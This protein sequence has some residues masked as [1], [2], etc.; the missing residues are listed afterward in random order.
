MRSG[1]LPEEHRQKFTAMENGSAGAVNPILAGR[2]LLGKG[3]AEGVDTPEEHE[4]NVTLRGKVHVLY[5]P[6]GV[7]KT[8]CLQ[9]L[10]KRAVGRGE[11]V[12]LLDKENGPRIVAERLNSMGVDAARVDEQLAYVPYPNLPLSL[13]VRT[14]YEELLDEWKPDLIL[15]DSWINFL[16]DADLDEN[17]SGDIASWA[18]AY[19]H[20]A[21]IR[22]ITVVLLDHVPHSGSHARGS[23]RKKDEVDV[24]WRVHRT[25]PFD[26][27]NV[28]E[29]ALHRE[30]DREGWLPQTVRFSV[31]GRG[32][33]T[34]LF[35]PSAGT[36][37][38][39][40]PFT[41]LTR[42]DKKILDI[43]RADFAL[44]GATPAEMTRR[45]DVSR[46]TFYRAK[47]VLIS[48]GLA[49]EG[50]GSRIYPAESVSTGHD[51]P[52]GPP[53]SGKPEV[54]Q[55]VSGV[56][57]ADS[58]TPEEKCVKCVTPLRGV[59]P[60]TPPDTSMVEG[61]GGGVSGDEDPYER[62]VEERRRTLEEEWL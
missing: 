38:G 16:A 24:L 23:T 9:W 44:S 60:D 58:D 57:H 18:I 4:P 7:G 37:E 30:K 28:G 46:K 43:L 45:A 40:D 22:G 13:E 47:T 25:K 33:G 56:C 61:S 14:A 5:G 53:Q 41:G 52:E 1:G 17:S 36:I 20:T 29:I 8:M 21:R 27:D 49:R 3:M 48:K 55:S 10:I 54:C 15:F 26:R 6:S 50:T 34:L 42:S 31:G 32:D 19:T 59:T 12:L 2:Y 39:E 11:R 51:T 62:M 35:E